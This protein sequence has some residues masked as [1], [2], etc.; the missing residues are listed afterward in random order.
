MKKVLIDWNHV[1][2]YSQIIAVVLFVGVFFLGY[3]LGVVHEDHAFT[4]SLRAGA[5]SQQATTVSADEK[6]LGD[7]TYLCDS[8]KTVRGIYRKESVEL[9]LSDGRHFS[10][11]QAVSGSGSRY[12][13]KDESIVFWNKGKT[14]FMTEGSK[15]TFANCVAKPISV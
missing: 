5:P 11:P 7:A 13:N 14:A 10:L 15:T 3:Y 9:L 8:D 2:R 4:N 12:A 6:I 1:T